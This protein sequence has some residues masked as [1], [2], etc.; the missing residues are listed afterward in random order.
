ME[1]TKKNLL[2]YAA[3]H[4]HTPKCIDSE[5]FFE[6]LKRFKYVKRLLNRYKETGVLSERLI[7]NHL[8]VIFNVFGVEA[9]LNILDLKIEKDHWNVLK[10]FLIFLKAIRN[11]QYTNIE[12]DK[13][14]I[15]KLREI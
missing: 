7:L 12:M 13:T 3:K 15:E 5:E 6:D 10:P 9:G 1:L 14:V 8:I 4:Y 11:D 2:I